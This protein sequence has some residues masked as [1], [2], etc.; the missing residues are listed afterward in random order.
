M[1]HYNS[2]EINR[3]ISPVP[4]MQNICAIVITY[5]PDT[6]LYDR[7]ERIASQVNKVIIVDNGSS[8]K[9]ILI[10]NKISTELGVHLI[11]NGISVPEA[12]GTC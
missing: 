12:N 6:E 11:L 3:K 9:N 7:I 4:N 10:L 8:E 2:P 1:N 5:H